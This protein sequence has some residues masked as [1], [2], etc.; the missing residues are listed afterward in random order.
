MSRWSACPGSVRL[1]RD[2]ENRA[3]SYAAE[4]T[5]AHDLAR[6]ALTM[7]VKPETY[8]GKVRSA[9][10]FDFTV[11]QEMVDAVNVYVESVNADYN[12]DAGDVLVV[13]HPLDLSELHPNLY[14][15]SDAGIW[16]PKQHLLIVK[17]YKH[18]AG[19][20]VEAK[21]NKQGRYYALGMLLNMKVPARRVRIE[22]VQ[23]RCPH[24]DGPIRSEEI[25]AIDLLDFSTDLIDYAKATED[26]AAPLHAGD[27]CRFCPAAALCPELQKRAQANA[28]QAFDAGGS[29]DPAALAKTLEWLPV[30][31][32]WIKN[33]REFAYN[34]AEHGR[35]PPGWKLVAK[36]ATR[37]WK[38]E[39]EAIQALQKLGLGE[40]ELYPIPKLNSPAQIEKTLGKKNSGVLETL[41]IKESS[42]HTLAP[43]SDPRPAVKEA[44]AD[45]FTNV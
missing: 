10:G 18:G 24:P 21:K 17:D 8:L 23:P 20:P 5:V 12:P 38:N 31:E 33:V 27:H 30:L 44:A 41:C 42:G 15:T 29:Y 25:D 40:P 4:G 3:T 13:E 9:D 7:K 2:V 32:G 14:G 16:K 26:E 39:I 19:V 6:I 36:R 22:I 43:D 11:D 34:E 35:T 1:S 45:A 28:A 37:K